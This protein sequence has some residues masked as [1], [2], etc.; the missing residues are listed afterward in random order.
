MNH[1]EQ[2]IDSV[3]NSLEGIRKAEPDDAVLYQLMAKLPRKS[4]S[5]TLSFRQ[6]RWAAVAAGVVVAFN[7]YATVKLGDSEGRQAVVVG[8]VSAYINA[9]TDTNVSLLNDYS[10]YN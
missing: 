5:T 10:L 1:D 3:M 9:D 4:L 2:W 6:L 8:N 7:L